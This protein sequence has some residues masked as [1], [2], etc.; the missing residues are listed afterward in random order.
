M[1]VKNSRSMNKTLKIT[2]AAALLFWSAGLFA[3]T[4]DIVERRDFW[5][6]G[7]NVNGLRTDSLTVSYAELGADYTSGGFRDV[8]DP[9]TIWSAG[10]EAGTITH[11]KKFSMIGA[12]SFRNAESQKAC[13]SMVLF[14]WYPAHISSF[15]GHFVSPTPDFTY[16][17]FAILISS[18]VCGL[19]FIPDLLRFSFEF[20][21]K[22][23]RQMLTYSIPLMVAAL[24]GIINDFL[25]RILFRYLDTN[26]EAWRSSLG[27]F[28]A[29]VKLSVIMNLFIQMFRFAA[30]PFFFQ[31]AQN[32]GSRQLYAIVMEYFTAFCGLILLGVFLYLDIFALIIGKDFRSGM[33][34]V[35]IMLLSYMLLGMLFNVSMWYKLSGKTG[36]AIWITLAGLVVTIIVNVL[37]MPRFSFWA[38]AFGHLASY[39]VMFIISA[40]LGARHYPI[41][42]SWKRICAIFAVIAVICVASMLLDDF[43]FPGVN[44]GTASA[45]KVI[46]KLAMH[47]VLLG[48]Y[49]LGCLG[50]LRGRYRL[51]LSAAE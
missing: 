4:F 3:Q 40:V 21:R 44:I 47:T 12:F 42:Y 20:D 39:L 26:A 34:V 23:L 50:I 33:G 46:L 51:A 45:G 30:E 27:I 31:R 15:M 18:V 10:A 32:K 28:Q 25:D 7:R 29:A 19:L 49:G 13:G 16:V 43:V 48:V 11:L 1:N 41:P 2:V 9:K 17:I 14:F 8:N 37:F 24:P 6:A 22:L 5:N 36:M 35:P 38:A